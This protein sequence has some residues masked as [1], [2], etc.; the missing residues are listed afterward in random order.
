MFELPPEYSEMIAAVAIGVLSAIFI[1]AFVILIMICRRQQAFKHSY[2]DGE[3]SRPEVMLI[4]DKSEVEINDIDLSK[5]MDEI[6]EDEQWVG[7]AT[8]LIPHCLSILKSCRYL[9]ERL[10]TLAMDTTHSKSGLNLIVENAKKISSR[11]DDMVQSM[12][13]PLDPRLLEA[14]AAALALAVSHLVLVARYECEDK[15]RNFSWIDHSLLEINQNLSVL[16]SAA[17]LPEANNQQVMP[18]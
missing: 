5:S 3:F 18:C 15:K 16:R 1:S 17:T 12:Y 14:R 10:A 9:T 2:V 6:L 11:V 4:S 13:P 7:D 8:G